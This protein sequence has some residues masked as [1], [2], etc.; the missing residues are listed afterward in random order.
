MD[1]ATTNTQDT[2]EITKRKLGERLKKGA[3]IIKEKVKATPG[4]I[5]GGIKAAPETAADMAKTATSGF[6][7]GSKKIVEKTGET[8]IT[9]G[10]NVAKGLGERAERKDYERAISGGLPS[11]VVIPSLYDDKIKSIDNE[12]KYLKRQKDEEIGKAEN[13][14]NDVIKIIEELEAK[15]DRLEKELDEAT[16]TLKTPNISTHNKNAA[17]SLA[18]RKERAIERTVQEIRGEK[19]KL[20]S[21]SKI[22]SKYDE[23][24]REKEAERFKLEGSKKENLLKYKA[25]VSKGKVDSGWKSDVKKTI[26]MFDRRGTTSPKPYKTSYGINTDKLL[27]PPSKDITTNLGRTIQ[28]PSGRRMGTGYLDITRNVKSGRGNMKLGDVMVPIHKQRANIFDSQTEDVSTRASKKY[29]MTVPTKDFKMPK[30]KKFGGSD[31]TGVAYVNEYGQYVQEEKPKVGLESLNI[32]G[33]YSNKKP[34]YTAKP[35]EEVRTQQFANVNG[36]QQQ[37]AQPQEQTY[38]DQQFNPIQG[39]SQ[40]RKNIKS[41]C[42][43]NNKQFNLT[44]ISGTIKTTNPYTKKTLK[45]KKQKK[46]DIINFPKIKI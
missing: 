6:A 17:E 28:P 27:K 41:T 42:N 43:K 38:G 2:P 44:R 18:I 15:K 5:V 35:K 22:S 37:C 46:G 12:I 40:F 21:L 9:G 45:L 11:D 16:E 33:V 13:I 31:K 39:T 7:S 36:L 20:E 34:L 10:K 23:R 24:I 29:K 25:A 14:K 4:A 3:D 1:D 32:R 19:S 26:E 8:I 30:L